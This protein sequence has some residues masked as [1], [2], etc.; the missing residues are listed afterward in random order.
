MTMISSC[1][2]ENQTMIINPSNDRVWAADGRK[3]I[4]AAIMSGIHL[5]TS[6]SESPFLNEL[7]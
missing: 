5:I 3:N 6:S 2:G 4:A 7:H 1:Y